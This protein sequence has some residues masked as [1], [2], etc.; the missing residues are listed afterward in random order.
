MHDALRLLIEPGRRAVCTGV[1]WSGIG[2]ARVGW[3]CIGW[4]RIGRTRIG[5]TRV[6]DTGIR[7]PYSPNNSPGAEIHSPVS[8]QGNRARTLGV[9]GLDDHWHRLAWAVLHIRA[10]RA[11]VAIPV[12]SSH[13]VTASVH[14]EDV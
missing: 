13:G 7:L 12:G 14:Q 8:N 1:T 2:W 11:G 9:R 10:V 4:T 3:A 5:G 6:W